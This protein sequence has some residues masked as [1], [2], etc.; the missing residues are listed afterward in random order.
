M[1]NK[2]IKKVLNY[3]TIMLLQI[4]F[5]RIYLFDFLSPVGF[6]FAIVLAYFDCNLIFLSIVYFVSRTF[7]FWQINVVFITLYEIVIISLFFFTKEFSKFKNKAVLLVLFSIIS[8]VLELYFSFESLEI[9]LKFLIGF[10]LKQAF[11][12]YFYMLIKTFKKKFLFFKFSHGDYF[13]FSVFAFILSLGMFGFSKNS[14]VAGL[15]ILS[16]TELFVLKILP[17]EKYLI[18]SCVFSIGAFVVTKNYFLLI[19]AELV[20]IFLSE[21]SSQNKVVVALGFFAFTMIFVLVGECYSVLLM[22]LEMLVAVAFVAIPKKW[23]M[24]FSQ[25]FD[26]MQVS[27][28]FKHL[29]QQKISDLKTRLELMADTFLNMN[30]DFKFLLVGKIDREQAGIELAG[31]VI[32]KTCTNCPNFR[33]C[34]YGNIN[35]REMFE[36]LTIKALESKRVSELD[37]SNGLQ[38]YCSKCSIVVSEINQIAMQF[39]K[40]ENAMKNEDSSKLLISDELKNFSDIFN[41]FS[42]T[43][44]VTIKQNKRLSAI[45]KENLLNNLLD[46]K[47]VVV[48]ENEDGIESI[49]VIAPNEQVLKMEMIDA[50]NKTTKIKFELAGIEHTEFSGLSLAVFKP[51]LKLRLAFSVSSKALS[52]KNGDNVTIKKLSNTK[53][54]IALADGMGHGEKAN[55]ISKM[56]LSLI[57]SMFE[58]GLDETIIISSINK[59]LIPAGL[60]NFTTLDAVV[61]DIEHGECEFIKLGSSVSVLKK[62]KTS[63]MIV[64]KSL[65]IGIVQNITP[66]I[67]KKSIQAGDMIFLA[68]D[69]VVDSFPS[70][71][72]YKTF[73]NDAKIYNTKKF[74]DDIISDAE[75]M[76][77]HQDDMT[78]IGV[79]LLKN[80]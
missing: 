66:T 39:E 78:I 48:L 50:L 14:L 16:F 58:V 26:P 33:S 13:L 74:L 10:A 11:V 9:F 73:I 55:R 40:F 63:E 28:I 46:A 69:G 20:S 22:I 45:V 59:L 60:D 27:M 52:S 70:V 65:P 34:F 53:Y 77:K 23:L 68:S 64:S 3:A 7:L 1:E 75:A 71:L 8:S 2:K 56:V 67:S 54:F 79:N 32:S 30:R 41:N 35:K 47:E 18:F 72:D 76:G 44:S 49:N 80:N 5:S 43:I 6:S 31:D 25:M 12:V 62:S 51:K 61:V 36:K 21:I 37:M 38:A 57:Q 42:K 15:V 4:V 29:E 19:Y 24:N 17:L